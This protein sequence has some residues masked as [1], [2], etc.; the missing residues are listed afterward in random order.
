[1]VSDNIN[2]NLKDIIKKYYYP[3]NLEIESE[4]RWAQLRIKLVKA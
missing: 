3:T 1:M 2:G 4:G